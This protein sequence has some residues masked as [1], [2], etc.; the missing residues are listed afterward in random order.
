MIE[1]IFLKHIIVLLIIINPISKIFIFDQLASGVA[2]QERRKR[3][4]E[5]AIA[6]VA[7]MMVAVWFG[8]GFLEVLAIH[9]GDFQIAG[10]ILIFYSGFTLMYEGRIKVDQSQKVFSV[11]PFGFPIVVGPGTL[12]VIIAFSTEYS[13]D[14]YKF[15]QSL[16]VLLVTSI[17]LVLML[18]S[19]K[20]ISALPEI[21][22]GICNKL[23]AVILMTIAIGMIRHGILHHISGVHGIN[24]S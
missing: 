24:I 5:S 11:V 4:F 20:I 15:W 14:V 23:M 21:S 22:I 8:R 12:S 10:G 19:K 18:F 7:F 9:I 13:K 16:E 2:N 3:A 17:V 1:H 6:M